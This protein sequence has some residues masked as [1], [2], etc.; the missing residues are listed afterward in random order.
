LRSSTISFVVSVRPHGTTRL[1]LDGF[2]WNLI[3]EIFF[4][5]LSRKFKF[6]YNQT[7]VRGT[8]HQDVFTFMTVFRWILRMRNVLD[9]SCRESKTHILCS[10]TFSRKSCRLWDNVEKYGGARETTNDVTI[11]RIRVACWISKATC[12]HAR[13]CTHKYVILI[14]FPRQQSLLERALLLHC[15]YIDCLVFFWVGL[16][17]NSDYFTVQH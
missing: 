5:N 14:A 17:T 3:F 15:T 6:H 4:E 12:T 9:K 2:W 8:L 1:P 16:R 7:K 11:W 10:V 13:A